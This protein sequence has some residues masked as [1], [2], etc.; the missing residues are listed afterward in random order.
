[1]PLTTKEQK[2]YCLW[3]G[4]T[5][6]SSA[7]T[8][9]LN[10]KLVKFW[11]TNFYGGTVSDKGLKKWQWEGVRTRRVDTKTPQGTVYGGIYLMYTGI[12]FDV[13]MAEVRLGFRCTYT[14]PPNCKW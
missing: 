10:T 8:K 9:A 3:R 14:P 11:L 5:P 13:Y 7:I 4:G 1:V 12:L 2:D 6:A